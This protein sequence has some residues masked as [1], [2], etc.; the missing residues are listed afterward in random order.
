MPQAHHRNVLLE[1]FLKCYHDPHY[2]IFEAYIEPTTG[3]YYLAAGHT[4]SC[5]ATH[6][7]HCCRGHTRKCAAQTPQKCYLGPPQEAIA[8]EAHTTEDV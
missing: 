6:R 3:E 4:Q 8:A 5:W 1:P 2:H 7:K